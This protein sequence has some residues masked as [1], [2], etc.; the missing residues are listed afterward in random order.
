MQT[1]PEH[2][3]LLFT[4]DCRYSRPRIERDVLRICVKNLGLMQG[5]PARTSPGTKLVY[6]PSCHFTFVQVSSSVRTLWPY[7]GDPKLGN[8]GQRL[9]EHDGPFVQR[10]DAKEYGFE[11]VMEDPC[12]WMNWEVKA[13]G[14]TLEIA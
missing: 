13:A 11:G 6:V 9:V 2:F 4:T 5:H 10:P 12:G 14:F 1:I 7:I 3:E 8:F